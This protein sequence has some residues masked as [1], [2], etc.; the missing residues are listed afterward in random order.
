VRVAKGGALPPPS[1]IAILSGY[2]YEWA[3]EPARNAVQRAAAALNSTAVV[4]LE[5]AQRA[6][7]AAFIITAAEGGALPH[8][9]IGVQLIS[10]PWCE[11]GCLA[12]AKALEDA[13]AA[14][15]RIA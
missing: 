6:R 11:D 1:R 8:L 4:D 12:A 15:C 9:P 13:G 3:T 10:A 14:R 7:A 5:G 2:F